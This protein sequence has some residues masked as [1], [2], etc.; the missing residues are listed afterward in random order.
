MGQ[1]DTAR[2]HEV[3]GMVGLW[4]ENDSV[5]VGGRREGQ[6]LSGDSLQHISEHH[7]PSLNPLT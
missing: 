6:Y 3:L 4:K 5:H 7:L 2:I 1:S